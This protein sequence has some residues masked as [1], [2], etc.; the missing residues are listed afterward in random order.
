MVEGGKVGNEI[1]EKDA[2][3]NFSRFD[4]ITLSFKI[5]PISFNNPP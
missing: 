1:R 2:V 4:Q 5:I 3:I